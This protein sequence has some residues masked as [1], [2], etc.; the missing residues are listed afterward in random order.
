MNK[1]ELEA[2]MLDAFYK[3]TDTSSEE[4]GCL[5]SYSAYR[6]ACTEVL[7]HVLKYAKRNNYEQS[8]TNK[9]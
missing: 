9:P 3:F 7:I 4:D 5:L 1:E 6:E 8:K 2:K